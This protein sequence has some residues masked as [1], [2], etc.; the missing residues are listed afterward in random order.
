M[1]YT[2]TAPVLAVEAITGDIPYELCYWHA[3]IYTLLC[4]KTILNQC[5]LSNAE[6]IRCVT[7]HIMQTEI[8]VIAK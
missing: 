3:V 7:D 1:T 8:A 2:Q 6:C 5:F 4:N